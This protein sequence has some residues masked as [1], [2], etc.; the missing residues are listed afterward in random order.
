M[1][2]HHQRFNWAYLEGQRHS[3]AEKRNSESKKAQLSLLLGI[4]RGISEAWD[5]GYYAESTQWNVIDIPNSSHSPTAPIQAP[6]RTPVQLNQSPWISAAIHSAPIFLLPLGSRF[7]VIHS[8]TWALPINATRWK[9][10]R[11]ERKVKKG[12]PRQYQLNLAH[13]WSSENCPTSSVITPPSS[14][15]IDHFEHRIPWSF[16]FFQ[17]TTNKIL[18]NSASIN[19]RYVSALH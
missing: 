15:L 10:K 18:S 5:R 7:N 11:K 14:A 13:D 6:R 2:F 1:R 19:T 3:E 9:W 17:I 4:E 16:I 12:G 8:S